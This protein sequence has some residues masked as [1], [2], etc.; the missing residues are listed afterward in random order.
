MSA[1][2]KVD[3][4]NNGC[5]HRLCRHQFAL[6][7]LIGYHQILGVPNKD[8][9]PTIDKKKRLETGSLFVTDNMLKG[10]R[11]IELK[12]SGFKNVT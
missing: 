11:Y 6:Q 2:I 7:L 12:F 1:A 4:E 9:I 5:F 10:C 3:L 8:S